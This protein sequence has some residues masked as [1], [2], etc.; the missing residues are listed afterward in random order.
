MVNQEDI[1]FWSQ[2][3][4]KKK[5]WLIQKKLLLL[6]QLHIK[7]GLIKQFV[8]A[9]PKEGEQFKYLCDQFPGLFEQKLKEG[10][11]VGH[12]IRKLMKYKNFEN[13]IK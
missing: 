7:L 11:F 8:K 1:R 13:K 3:Y 10:V 12:D 2:K 6:P 9:L 5:T 4:S